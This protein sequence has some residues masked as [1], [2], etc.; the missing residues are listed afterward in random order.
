MQKPTQVVGRRVVAYI[1]DWLII[2]A[3]TAISWYLLTTDVSPGR[4][5]GGG[6]EINNKCRG[7]VASESSHRTIWIIIIA[8][9]VIGILIVMQ[10][11]TGKTPGKAA[12]G[13][14]VIKA[15][16]EPPGIGRAFLRE[17]LWIVDGLPFLNLVGLITALTTQNNQRV[18]DMAASTFV[19]D[20][21][22]AGAIGGSPAGGQPAFAGP[23]PTGAPVGA[24]PPPAQP[25]QAQ[26]PAG[27][28]ANWYPDPQGQARLRYWDGER[29]T[30]HTSA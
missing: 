18:G 1:I 12:V 26:Q 17:I 2:A 15:D 28:A 8:V 11:L 24:P 20:R 6:I 13:I 25:Q 3:I 9:A 19:V 14:K 29:W 21:N 22:F 16:G 5:I 27:Q 4:C 23:P 30:E 10:G 7:F